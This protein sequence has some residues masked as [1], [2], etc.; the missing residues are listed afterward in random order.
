MD[1]DNRV[2]HHSIVIIELA[3]NSHL[4]PSKLV[5]YADVWLNSPE[6]RIERGADRYDT[7]VELGFE[8]LAKHLDGVTEPVESPRY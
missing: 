2:V 8:V 1:L 3:M 7:R 4:T 5:C 6:L